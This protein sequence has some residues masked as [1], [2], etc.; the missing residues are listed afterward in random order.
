[1]TKIL[2]AV[3]YQI[4]E[5]MKPATTMSMKKRTLLKMTRKMRGLADDLVQV[6]E[7]MRSVVCYSMTEDWRAGDADSDVHD[8][9][10]YPMLTTILTILTVVTMMSELMA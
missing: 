1:M 7:E 5:M 6:E 9:Q 2:V 8:W 10:I 4:G 3:Y